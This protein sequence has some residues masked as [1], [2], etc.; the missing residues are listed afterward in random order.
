MKG[1][2]GSSTSATRSRGS[3]CPRLWKRSLAAADAARAR[4]SR[5]R[6]REISASMPVR[7][8]LKESLFGAIV[9]SMIAMNLSYSSFRDA[10][11]GAGPESIFPI[12][13]MDSGL[14]LRAPRND[15][16]LL[17]WKEPLRALFGEMFAEC[18][19]QFDLAQF[20]AFHPGS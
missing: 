15:G 9:D 8:V 11:L 2:P 5:P 18:L 13:V 1:E 12:V 10:P 4:C 3:N 19:A 6:I 16:L 17:A 20:S 7:L 14:A